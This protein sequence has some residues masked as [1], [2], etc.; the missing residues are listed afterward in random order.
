MTNEYAKTIG[1]RIKLIRSNLGLSMEEFGKMLNPVATKG[2]VSKWENGKYIPNN[3]R[4]KTIADLGNTTAA[5]LLRPA[6]GENSIDVAVDVAKDI[7]YKNLANKENFKDEIQLML[8]HFNNNSLDAVL[9]QEVLHYLSDP[10]VVQ[11]ENLRDLGNKSD[12]DTYLIKLLVDRYK[13]EVPTNQHLIE[14]I[15]KDIPR[16]PI[17][18]PNYANPSITNLSLKKVLNDDPE[19]ISNDEK[20]S[21]EVLAKKGARLFFSQ[22]EGAV[23]TE[24]IDEISTILDETRKQLTNLVNKYPDTKSKI[25]QQTIVLANGKGWS[26]RGTVELSDSLNIPDST[27]EEII[28]LGHSLL[29]KADSFPSKNIPDNDISDSEK[30]IER[31]YGRESKY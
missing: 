19:L 6:D 14:S 17:D 16:N 13:R 11:S 26:Q 3:E 2:T 12:F 1:S 15:Y 24:L 22:Y 28:A 25:E 27:K 8:E 10:D 18:Y 7:F 31:I 4:L 5:F 20:P 29:I 21:L 9:E 23:S 30:I